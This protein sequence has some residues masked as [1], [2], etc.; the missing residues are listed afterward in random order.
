MSV[1][2][3]DLFK[4]RLL[5]D[6]G[7]KEDKSR[8]EEKSR[9]ERSRDERSHREERSRDDKSRDERSHREDRSRDDRSRDER[10]AASSQRTP[11]PAVATPVPPS[12]KTIP[13]APKTTGSLS[14]SE[15]ILATLSPTSGGKGAPS[16]GTPVKETEKTKTPV[17][18][19]PK[20]SHRDSTKESHR[21]SHRDST[22]ESPKDALKRTPS[23]DSLKDTPVIVEA[24]PKRPTLSHEEIREK[25]A[26]YMPI[27][28]RHWTDIKRG[29]HVR[30]ITT[31]GLFHK[32]GYVMFYYEDEG[33]RTIAVESLPGGKVGDKYYAK[34]TAKL[35]DIQMLYC[36]VGIEYYVARAMILAEVHSL[37]EDIKHLKR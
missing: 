15:K 25:L 16:K 10:S 37:R 28:K 4:K 19:T 35:D 17:K 9:D 12:P 34:Y 14:I 2:S 3:F 7:S 33:K 21:E 29:D 18:E 31:E 27:P 8:K 32:G 22:K 30:W 5:F 36:K 20:D 11:K 23:R 6:G 26:G 24:K 13:P 1:S